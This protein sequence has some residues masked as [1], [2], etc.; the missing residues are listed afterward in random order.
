VTIVRE[1]VRIK[2]KRCKLFS[3]FGYFFDCPYDPRCDI[4][5]I[6]VDNF[7]QVSLL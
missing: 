5:S 1:Q 7:W 4:F 3:D 6:P 2:S